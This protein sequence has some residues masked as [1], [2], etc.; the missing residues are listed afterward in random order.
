MGASVEGW[1]L[2]DYLLQRAI[3]QLFDQNP[4]LPLGELIR[5]G[6]N[7]Y[8]IANGPNLYVFA[9]TN[10]YHLLGDP[11]MRLGVPQ[12]RLPLQVDRH[13]LERGANLTA[14]AHLPF[15]RGKGYAAIVDSALALSDWR[16]APIQA[17]TASVQ[18]EVPAD[19]AG[20][21]GHLVF[22]AEDELELTAFM[23]LLL[24]LWQ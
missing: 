6:K 9:E 17:G 21:E 1:V 23:P 19:F 12:K 4:S 16:E 8:Q 20:S 3:L 7:L 24:F 22:Y 15:S 14:A 18:V 11:A 13:L 10:Q 5:L 2:N